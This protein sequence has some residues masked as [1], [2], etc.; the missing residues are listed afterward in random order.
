[1]AGR[2]TI[3][4]VAREAGVSVTRVDRALNGRSVVREE[5]MRRIAESAHRV[6]YHGKGIFPSRLIPVLPE[7]RFGFVLLKKSQEFY[8]NFAKEIEQAVAERSDIMGRV[9]ICFSSSQSPN[10]F[11]ELL[12]D[13]VPWL[14]N[15]PK[16]R[17]LGRARLAAGSKPDQ[18]DAC[19][20]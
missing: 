8:Q 14:S 18:R 12:T 5:T 3:K 20:A 2:P 11:A 6:G 15:S 4:D 19:S 16:G 1:M 17:P 10:E 13:L 9:D 7:L